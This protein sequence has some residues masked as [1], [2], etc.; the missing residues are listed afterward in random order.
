MGWKKMR[1]PISTQDKPASNHLLIQSPIAL[2]R[3]LAALATSRGRRREEE[4]GK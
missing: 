2:S 4:P 1:G 3:E